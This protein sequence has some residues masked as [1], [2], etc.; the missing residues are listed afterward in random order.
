MERLGHQ[1]NSKLNQCKALTYKIIGHR[2]LHAVFAKLFGFSGE[3][4]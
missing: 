4:L 2:L 3:G 1:I